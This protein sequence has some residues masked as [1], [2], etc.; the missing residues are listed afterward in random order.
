[1]AKRFNIE[2]IFVSAVVVASSSKSQNFSTIKGLSLLLRE[3]Y[4][5]YEIIV[6]T[7]HAPFLESKETEKILNDLPCIRIIELSRKDP[8]D[9]MIFAGIDS[10]IGDTVVVLL[11][12][13]DPIEMLPEF[14]EHNKEHSIVFGI[15]TSRIRKGIVNEYGSRLFYWYNK[16]FLGIYIPNRSTYYVAFNRMAV[17]ALTR[18]GRQA[19]HI[20][21]LARQVGYLYTSLNYTPISDY[22]EKRR[23]KDLFISAIELSTNY[24]NHPLRFISWLG[25]VAALLNVLYA[26]YVLGVG[27]F[28]SEVAAG[29][30]SSSLQLSIMFFLLFAI[31]A[32]LSEYIGKI[33]QEARKEQPYHIVNEL[34]SKISVADATRRNI[35]KG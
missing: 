24:S 2:N 17:N 26:L 5:N 32:I 19:K 11:A 3:R 1:M 7:E 6:V 16:K 29:W 23:L 4:A 14:V 8:T 28:K 15:S 30:T 35:D 34:N 13:K 33:L 10:A 21:H 12:G 27:L 22:G 18:N 25:F 31:L 20:R 9:V